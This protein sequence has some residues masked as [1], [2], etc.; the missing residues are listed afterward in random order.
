MTYTLDANNGR[1]LAARRLPGVEHAW[2]GRPHRVELAGSVAGPDP[3]L[4]GG[5]G[6]TIPPSTSCTGYPAPVTATVTY[7]LTRTTRCRSATRPSTRRRRAATPPSSTSPTTRTSTSVVR[8]AARSSTSCFQINANQYTPINE[9]LI[10]VGFEPV[11]GT[12]FD[13]TRM[14]PIGQ[15]IRNPA[16]DNGG[17]PFTQLVIAHGYDH[18][19]V[20]NG[21]GYRLAAVAQDPK[22]GIA[23]WTYTDQPGVQLYTGNFLV[24]DSDRDEWS[25]L[26]ADRRVHARDPALPGFAQPHR[27][28]RMAV[29]GAECR[30]H[31]RDDDVVQVLDR[32][33]RPLRARHQLPVADLALR[34]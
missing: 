3:Q 27:P 32:R 24:G 21:S 18:N 25:H 23:M 31:V 10:P 30:Q 26:P 29:G 16:G 2:C 15:D 20:L 9:N 34:G 28:D 11:A 14:K 6:C 19:F 33:P 1:E 13:F 17:Q 7:T 4:P 8:P 22:D 12:A 5:E